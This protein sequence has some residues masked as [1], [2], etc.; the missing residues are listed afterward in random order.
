MV[1]RL[2][3]AVLEVEANLDGQQCTGIFHLSK[4]YNVV[5]DIVRQ[6]LIGPT[7]ELGARLIDVLEGDSDESVL[8]DS[9]RNRQGFVIDAGGGTRS[10]EITASLSETPFGEHGYL[11]MGDTGDETNLTA[12][13]ATG[14]D[15]R[16]QADV[17]SRFVSE[18]TTDSI[19]SATLHIGHYHDGTYTLDGQ[20]GL[21]GSP[22]AVHIP[23]GP[24]V[25][26]SAEDASAVEI[27]IT[28]NVVGSFDRALDIDEQVPYL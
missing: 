7:G 8:G 26:E 5:G 19:N 14:A 17:F 25:T 21:F 10:Y 2:T 18:A 1:T 22:R 6:Y 27:T 16:T 4:D 15:A 23:E 11:Q 20:P 24:R 3:G 28:C 12:T 9:T 13:D